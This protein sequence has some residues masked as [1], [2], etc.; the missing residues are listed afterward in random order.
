MPRRDGA[1][2]EHRQ[3]GGKQRGGGGED[4]IHSG[5]LGRTYGVAMANADHMITLP[6]LPSGSGAGYKIARSVDRSVMAPEGYRN[7]PDG[8][9]PFFRGFQRGSLVARPHGMSPDPALHTPDARR[10]VYGSRRIE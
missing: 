1:A 4:V 10:D 7:R 3:A 5:S 6:P 8:N 2:D 9:R